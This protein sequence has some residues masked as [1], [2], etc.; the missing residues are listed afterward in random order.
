MEEPALTSPK[1]VPDLPL[2]EFSVWIILKYLFTFFTADFHIR[3]LY[4]PTRANR[5]PASHVRSVRKAKPVE[6][7]C[8]G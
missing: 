2:E 4:L 8:V 6:T 3:R 1:P 7:L 5:F